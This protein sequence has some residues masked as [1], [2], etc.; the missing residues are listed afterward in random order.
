M[1]TKIGNRKPQNGTQ[2]SYVITAHSKN[3]TNT[4]SKHLYFLFFEW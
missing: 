1:N 3:L 2:D 4:E